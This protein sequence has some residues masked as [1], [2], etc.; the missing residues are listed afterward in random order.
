MHKER[1]AEIASYISHFR[2]Q[3]QKVALVKERLHQKILTV[4]LISTLAE[5]RYTNLVRD[6]QKFISLIENN[7]GWVQG[8]SVNV[9]HLRQITDS[10][11]SVGLSGRFVQSVHDA[12]GEVHK[13]AHKTVDLTNDPQPSALLPASPNKREQDL[14]EGAKH[15]ALLYLYRCKLVHEFREQGY[16]WEFEDD[17]PI[18]R[19]GELVYPAGWL[20]GLVPAIITSLETYYVSTGADPRVGYKFGSPWT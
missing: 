9:V 19:F 18:Y 14:V 6:K 5:G 12:C 16:P 11:G 7:T 1:Q 8:Q 10:Q 13:S 15:S 17:A 2:E 4:T 3:H 20:L